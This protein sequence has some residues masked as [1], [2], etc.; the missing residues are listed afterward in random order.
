MAIIGVMATFL[1]AMA[2]EQAAKA[3]KEKAAAFRHGQTLV[4][5]R[6]K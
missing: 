1:A 5:A 6:A 4:A 3:L 2:I